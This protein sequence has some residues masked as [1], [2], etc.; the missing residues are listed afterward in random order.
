WSWGCD[1]EGCRIRPQIRRTEEHELAADEPTLGKYRFA[2]DPRSDGFVDF[3][4]TENETNN[5]RIFGSPNHTPF[6]KDA[7]H[8]CVIEGRAEAVNPA[9]RGTKVAAHYRVKI[10][11]GRSRVFKLRLSADKAAP[12]HVFGA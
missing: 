3:L 10:E 12:S 7:F 2:V 4:F 8:A 11:A 6:V 1:E 5:A 9:Q